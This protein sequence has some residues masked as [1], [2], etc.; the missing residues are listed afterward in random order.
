[1][2]TLIPEIKLKDFQ[3]LSAPEIKRLQC[4]EVTDEDG[5]YLFTFIRPATDFIR[6]RSE[7][8]GQLSNSV[9]GEPLVSIKTLGEPEDYVSDKPY[10]SK[11][12]SKNGK[13][14][15]KYTRKK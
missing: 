10:K 12:K 2:S 4:C 9:G 13:A 7:Y 3:G 8:N 1:M 14:K 5:D 11:K 6:V 15:R